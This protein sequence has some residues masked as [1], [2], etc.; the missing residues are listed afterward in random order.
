[1]NENPPPLPWKGKNSFVTWLPRAAANVVYDELSAAS[2]QVFR[3]SKCLLTGSAWW[4]EIRNAIRVKSELSEIQSREGLKIA[5]TNSERRLQHETLAVE[6]E[7]LEIAGE[8]LQLQREYERRQIEGETPNRLLQIAQQVE[9]LRRELSQARARLRLE[10][11][12]VKSKRIRSVTIEHFEKDLV[13]PIE[14]AADAGVA[15][16]ATNDH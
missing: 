3:D 1:M 16:I 10:L 14:Q 9:I 4:D 13:E 12:R 5:Q 2:L 11:D 7:R 15:L 6:R 8:K